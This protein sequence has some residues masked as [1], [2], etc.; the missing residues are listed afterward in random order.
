MVGVSGI[1]DD[2]VAHCLSNVKSGHLKLAIYGTC[3]SL[4][5]CL[6]SQLVASFGT[7]VSMRSVM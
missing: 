7:A 6:E 2:S 4:T 3:T 1:D 5:Y